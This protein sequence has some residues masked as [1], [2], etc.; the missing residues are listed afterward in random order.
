MR[1]ILRHLAAIV[2]IIVNCQLSIVNSSY[3]QK[4]GVVL[5]GGSAKGGAHI[6]VLKALEEQ[7]IPID[8]ITG[9]SIGAIVGA[10]YASGYTLQEIEDLMSSDE[11]QHWA[12]GV[13]DE[14]YIYYFWKEDPNASWVSTNFNL[15]KKFTAMLPT[16]LIKTWEIDFNVMRI[17]LQSGAVCKGDF[18]SLMVPFRCV[19]A[20]IDSTQA[21]VLRK[22]DLSAAVRGSMS[23]PLVFNPVVLDNKLVFDGGMYNN[24]PCDVM[25]NTFH[26]D[27]IIG[28]RVSQRYKKPD[29]DDVVSQILSMLMESQS[30]TLRY[31]GS[32]M[33][34]P[35]IPAI[36]QLDFSRTKELSDSG[37]KAAMRKI[38]E[39]RKYVK[40]SV[41]LDIMRNK[42]ASFNVHKPKILFDSIHVK[43]MNKTQ[44]RYIRQILKHGQ[45]TVT[46]EEL[47]HEYFRFISE[48]FIQS[49][50]PVARFNPATGHFD[51][52]LDIQKA[53]NF[54]AAFGGNFSLA[55]TSEAFLQVDYKYL[56][57]KGLRFYMNGY[58]GRIYSAAKLGGRIDF[59]SKVPWFVEASYTYNH[60]NYFMSTSFFFDDKTPNYIIE[61][62]YFGD[63][64]VGIPATNNGK[65]AFGFIDAYTNKRYYQNNIFSRTDTADQTTFRFFSPSLSFDLNSLNQK[66]YPSAGVRL[67]IDFSYFNGKENMIPGSTAK[68]RTPVTKY[69]SWF[70]LKFLYENYFETFGPLKLGFYGEAVISDQPLFSN[71]ISSL[72]YATAFQPVP[73]SQTYFLTSFRAQ[74]YAAAG[75]KIVLRVYKKIEYRLE[76]Y[77]FQPYREILENQDDYSAYFG[78]LFGRRSYMASTALVYHSPIGPLSIVANYFD[79]FP[80]T[81]TVNFNIG[82]LIFNRRAMP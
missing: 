44:E 3:A 24:F 76:G 40:D 19:V 42:R 73:E 21:L 47:R 72:L 55:N 38:T 20:D 48:G 22:G 14:D 15:N 5:S 78:P 37:Y 12:S 18:D 75:L 81:F 32:V 65:I 51:L 82:Y 2:F 62:E 11:F 77:I 7:G 61:G 74:S 52:Y 30:D 29:R 1:N 39:I 60:F 34:T 35:D 66:Q 67:M 6:G 56:W 63:L 28:S 43:G 27:V 71:Y 16:H 36:S 31:P 17:F 68:D 23:I 59:N 49:I 53:D 26:P 57:T 41:T 70:R 80:E 4:V 25:F 64:R 33:I 58:F 79:K 69:H 10:L 8:Y 50:F 54:G 13:V 46:L 9:T 45:K